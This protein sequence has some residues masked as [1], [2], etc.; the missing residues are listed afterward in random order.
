MDEPGDR[1]RP[2]DSRQL[3][4]DPLSEVLQTLLVKLPLLA[5]L[6]SKVLFMRQNFIVDFKK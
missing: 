4:P 6:Q 3:H 5:L 2:D 1:L